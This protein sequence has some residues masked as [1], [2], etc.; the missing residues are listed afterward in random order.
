MKK[1]KKAVYICIAVLSVI[2][3]GMAVVSFLCSDT[4]YQISE[5]MI[6]IFAIIA[7]MLVFDAVESLSIGNVLSLKKQVKE[8]EEEVSKLNEENQ[9]LK[10][11]LIFMMNS[12]FHNRN[13]N[14]IFV[15]TAANV[16]EPS[17]EKSTDSNDGSP[18]SG[19]K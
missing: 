4:P 1:Q 14:Q 6:Y 7:A 13:S 19:L 12:T 11:Q 5:S 17:A 3:V 10:N 18:E 8:K 16:T 2:M 15:G 9:Q